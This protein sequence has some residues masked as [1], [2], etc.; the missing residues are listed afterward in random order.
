MTLY[1][2]RFGMELTKWVKTKFWNLLRSSSAI[3]LLPLCEAMS[4]Y[5]PA[6]A[7]SGE[8]GETEWNRKVYEKIWSRNH[9]KI[10]TPKRTTTDWQVESRQRTTKSSRQK[11]ARLCRRGSSPSCS[12]VPL[13]DR[14]QG[15]RRTSF[16]SR[17]DCSLNEGS[18]WVH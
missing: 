8:G 11:G 10:S 15:S 13:V 17:H 18:N 16:G 1:M 6:W 5:W 7:P 14:G 3:S 12:V 9:D 2:S 4:S